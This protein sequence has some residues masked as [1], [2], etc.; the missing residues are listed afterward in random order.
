MA[1]KRKPLK[2]Q[3]GSADAAE[4]WRVSEQ[5]V[6][7]WCLDGRIGGARKIGRDWILPAGAAPPA[8]RKPGRPKHAQAFVVVSSSLATN[9]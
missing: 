2:E 3:C 8:K 4:W 5:L 9:N 6:R 7:R 1:Q